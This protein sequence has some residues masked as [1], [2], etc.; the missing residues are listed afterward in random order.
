VTR[1]EFIDD[2]GIGAAAMG[3]ELEDKTLEDF[4]RYYSEL[5][6]WN[7]RVNLV[8]RREPDWIGVHFLDSLAALGLGLVPSGVRLVDLG[9]GAGFPGV[10]LKLASPGLVLDLAEASEKK[11][12]WLRH[13]LRVLKIEGATVLEGRFETLLEQGCSGGYDLAVS[14]AAARPSR[15]VEA[16]G[17]FLGP[18]GKL[19]V[20]TTKDLVDTG[21]GKVHLYKIPGSKTTS[22]IWE[23]TI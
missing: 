1:Q 11:C 6:R 18:G 8:S 20:Y 3:I 4:F 5:A 22:V 21:M 17:P 9:A 19:L 23:V 15:I 13:L 14:R 12:A 2:F 16:A 10:P 7:A